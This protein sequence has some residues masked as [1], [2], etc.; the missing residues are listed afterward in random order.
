MK[1][2]VTQIK[3]LK[4]VLGDMEPWIK[5]PATL[6]T[7]KPGNF[8]L[9]PR[10]ILANWLLCAVGNAQEPERN[11]TFSNDPLGCGDGIIMDTTTDYKM[12]TEHVFIPK[13][14]KDD[15][16]TGE[17]LFLAA[18]QKK[19]E[20]GG[21]AY[22]KGKHLVV[23]ADG[24]GIWFPNKVGQAI[25]G[26]HDFQEVWGVGLEG[27]D[28]DNYSYWVVNFNEKHS[29]AASVNINFQDKSWTVS[30]IQ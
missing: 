18:I 12:V 9:L 13:H 6:Y 5:N 23:F 3:D 20:K 15:K 27:V 22:A 30:V 8:K 17:E 2:Q 26:K 4:I 24:A 1:Q 29:P 11:F 21:K 28:G 14:Q 25:A 19:Q 16:A 10:E 7:G